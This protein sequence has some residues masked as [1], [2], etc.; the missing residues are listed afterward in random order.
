MNA[1]MLSLA[2]CAATIAGGLFALRWRARLPLALGFTAGALL[3]VVSFELIPEA[4]AIS[5]RSGTDGRTAMV[6]LVAGFLLFLALHERVRTIGAGAMVAHSLMDGIGIG[7]AFQVSPAM[8]AA[9][10]LAVVA[11]DFCDGLNTTAIMI[12][13]GSSRA[14]ALAMLAIDALAPVAGVAS[15]SWLKVP[16]HALVNVLGFFAGFLL[17]VG[18]ADI[19]PRAREVA[20]AH[21]GRLL[22]L[23]GLGASLPYVAVRVAG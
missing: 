1:V 4:F 18:I 10:A 15:A 9:V 20:A 7:L 17:Y 14:A 21:P 13:Q 8:G 22:A 19:L 12:V 11:H 5:M 2:A 3:G 16:P 6:A 23:S